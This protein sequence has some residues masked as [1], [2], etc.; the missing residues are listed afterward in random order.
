MTKYHWLGSLNN[1]RLF[2]RVLETGSPRSRCWKIWFRV[3]ILF[4]AS[5]RLPSYVAERESSSVSSSS[6]GTGPIMGA[7]PSRFHLNLKKRKKENE[8]AQSCPTLCDPMDCSLPGSPVH[9]I[10]QARIPEWV[11]IS[12]SR[13]SSRLRDGTWVSRI[14]GRCFYRLSHQGESSKSNCFPKYHHL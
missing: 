5:W 7:P 14:V 3:R 10:F 1:S 2:L 11:A 13:G 12:F 6:K 4:L 9:G 8:V